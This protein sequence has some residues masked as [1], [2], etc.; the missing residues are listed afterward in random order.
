V[1]F[2]SHLGQ[3]IRKIIAEKIIADVERKQYQKNLKHKKAHQNGGLLTLEYSKKEDFPTE[4]AD[5]P[6][7]IYK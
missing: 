6:S 1:G 7:Y 4:G 3:D 2:T 5:D